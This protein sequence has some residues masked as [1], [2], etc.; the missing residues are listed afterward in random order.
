MDR[1]ISPDRDAGRVQKGGKTTISTGLDG[2]TG[3]P[4]PTINRRPVGF[5]GASR[6]A[7]VAQLVEHATENR[8]VGGSIPPLGTTL[9]PSGYAWLSH[10]RLKGEACPAKPLGEDGLAQQRPSRRLLGKNERRTSP[11]SQLSNSMSSLRGAKRRSNPQCIRSSSVDCFASLA[12][13]EGYDSAFPRHDSAR[14]LQSIA[15]ES[16]R[17]QGMPGARCTRSR[18]RGGR[19]HTR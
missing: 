7:Q 18:V 1:A 14:V 4:D 6:Y 2:W 13:T 17:A 5:L 16:Q 19:K 3:T 11:D 15:L 8:S 9:R 12:M 10:A